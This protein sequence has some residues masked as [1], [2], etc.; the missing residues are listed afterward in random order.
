MTER[1]RI[2]KEYDTDGNWEYCY[3]DNDTERTFNF[4]DDF[5]D[6]DFI[7]YVNAIISSLT[8]EN[9]QLKQPHCRKCSYFSCDNADSYCMKKEFDSIDDFNIAKNCKDYESVF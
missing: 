9:E 5:C 8:D 3:V 6:I 2:D 4:A 7:E 1:F